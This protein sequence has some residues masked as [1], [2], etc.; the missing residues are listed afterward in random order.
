MHRHQAWAL[1]LSLLPLIASGQSLPRRGDTRFDETTSA[2]PD[3]TV[4]SVAKFNSGCQQMEAIRIEPIP[5]DFDQE[6]KYVGWNV[7]LWTVIGCDKEFPMWVAW[8]GP[9]TLVGLYKW[10][11]KPPN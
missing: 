2:A 7:E 10:R 4:I 11:P 9:I 6:H 8:R 1:L 5:S 3:S